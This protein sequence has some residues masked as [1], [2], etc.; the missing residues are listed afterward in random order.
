M[1][2]SDAHSDE[3]AATPPNAD[4]SKRARTLL[5]KTSDRTGGYI[6][7]HFVR[8]TLNIQ[9]YITCVEICPYFLT[10]KFIMGI[11]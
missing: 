10:I 3:N 9:A 4:L 1:V 7:H 8:N 6:L 2:S 11:K 5:A